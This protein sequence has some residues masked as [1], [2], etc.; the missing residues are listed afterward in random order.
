MHS[1]W[2]GKLNL[3]GRKIKE[4]IGQR[5]NKMLILVIVII[6][7]RISTSRQ[8]DRPLATQQCDS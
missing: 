2:N 5:T 4:I 6:M 1:T 3:N 8:Y 7:S